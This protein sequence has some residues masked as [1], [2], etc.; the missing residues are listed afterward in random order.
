MQSFSVQLSTLQMDTVDIKHMS[1]VF[2]MVQQ[3]KTHLIS[4]NLPFMK[5]GRFEEFELFYAL[6]ACYIIPRGFILSFDSSSE[7]LQSQSS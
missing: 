5:G 1:K 4:L 6:T 7:K 2:V 3:S